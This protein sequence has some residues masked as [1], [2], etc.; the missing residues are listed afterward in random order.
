[1]EDLSAWDVSALT[2]GAD[3][4]DG[5][6]SF[7]GAGLA[8]WDVSLVRVFAQAFRGCTSFVEDISSWNVVSLSA[9]DNMFDG[10]T[11]FGQ[12][13]CLWGT[14]YTDTNSITDAFRN[15]AC[16]STLDP[17]L[18]ASPKGPWCHGCP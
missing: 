16:P 1:M 14:K 15:T 8:N 18:F 9:M 10:A 12:D 17:N 4:F 6:T 2:F 3:M 11:A 7:T 5:A 13:L